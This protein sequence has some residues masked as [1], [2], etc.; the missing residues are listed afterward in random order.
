MGALFACDLLE[1]I[2]TSIRHTSTPSFGLGACGREPLLGPTLPPTWRHLF[3]GFWTISRLVVRRV[4][5]RYTVQSIKQYKH[6]HREVHYWVIYLA[7]EVL[8]L[9]VT[10][11]MRGTTTAVKTSDNAPSQSTAF[12]EQVVEVLKIGASLI[13]FGT[14]TKVIVDHL[15]P[16]H[17]TSVSQVLIIALGVLTVIVLAAGIFAGLL[18]EKHK[19]S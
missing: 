13:A 15:G 5:A 12:T 17:G 16:D 18:A 2:Y 7:S 19:Q 14:L 6:S 4:P 3:L 9:V 8:I 10:V 1:S 11:R